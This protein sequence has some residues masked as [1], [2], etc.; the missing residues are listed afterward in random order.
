MKEALLTFDSVEEFSDHE[1]DVLD[2]FLTLGLSVVESHAVVELPTTLVD[3][4]VE[5][6]EGWAARKRRNFEGQIVEYL[7]PNRV[8]VGVVFLVN[9]LGRRDK[10]FVLFTV[11]YDGEMVFHGYKPCDTG[12]TSGR[13]GHACT[14]M[15]MVLY[16]HLLNQ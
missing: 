6:R 8:E 4:R 10:L 11:M 15:N 7:A 1:S 2:P 13:Y 16:L 3:H 5:E 12:Y 14:G 9:R